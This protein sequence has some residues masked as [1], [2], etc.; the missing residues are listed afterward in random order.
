MMDRK[1]RLTITILLGIGLLCLSDG[2]IRQVWAASPTQALA[3]PQLMAATWIWQ[4][5]DP[6]AA[7]PTHSTDATVAVTRDG[8]TCVVWTET[9][10]AGWPW[11]YYCVGDGA[12]WSEPSVL[13]IGQ[14]PD[15]A[16]SPDGVVHLVYSS[17]LFGNQE[18]YHTTWANGSWTLPEN[19]SN[20]EGSS[21]QPAIAL[22]S[23]GQP[24]IVWTES[25]GGQSRIYYAWRDGHWATYLIPATGGG[26]AP[27][28]AIGEA[29]RVWVV[30]QALE[31]AHHDVYALYG[32]RAEGIAW[33][34]VAMNISDSPA[35]DSLTPALV[36]APGIGA[37]L[38]WQEREQDIH[39]VYYADNL[40]YG[41]FWG[42]PVCLSPAGV[43][44]ER[45]SIAATGPG[46]V[47]VA[48]DTGKQLLLRY[49]LPDKSWSPQTIIANDPI[50]IGPVAL[51]LSPDLT[52]HAVWSQQLAAPA[53]D[54]YHRSGKLDWPYHAWLALALS[55]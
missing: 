47:R 49:R 29:G 31:G 51:A 6:I 33:A 52:L 1:I 27:D 11:L 15:L 9:T 30:W 42:E 41:A 44:S 43:S 17:E 35:N 34:Q 22:G 55:S 20:T 18:I 38:V 40:E 12:G 32:T 26:S 19:V 8:T 23:D 54:I 39:R 21:T 10:E 28:V 45:P 7:T 14:D 53:H 5:I 25:A 37:F 16:V 50:A 4:P 13:F 48:W 36:G 2:A 46:S 3:A 24:V